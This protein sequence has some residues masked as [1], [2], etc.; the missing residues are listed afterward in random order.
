MVLWKL[1][2]LGSK[3]GCLHL[4]MGNCVYCKPNKCIWRLIECQTA[5]PWDDKITWKIRNQGQGSNKVQMLAIGRQSF[6][7]SLHISIYKMISNGIQT[8]ATHPC[9]IKKVKCSNCSTNVGQ[10]YTKISTLNKYLK[11]YYCHNCSSHAQTLHTYVPLHICKFAHVCKKGPLCFTWILASDAFLSSHQSLL[12]Y[13]WIKKSSYNFFQ[14]V[15][16]P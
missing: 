4:R 7:I 3:A 8:E 9:S 14:L 5:S 10:R 12:D 6:S 13:S 1:E 11:V 16:N 2:I 15:N